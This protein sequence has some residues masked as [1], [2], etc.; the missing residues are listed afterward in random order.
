MNQRFY[1]A[2]MLLLFLNSAYAGSIDPTVEFQAE[3]LSRSNQKTLRWALKDS[4]KAT[5]LVFISSRCP[6]SAGHEIVLTKIAE[7][8]SSLGFRFIGVHANANESVSEARARFEDVKLGFPI[9]QDD[10][11]KIANLFGALK[12]PHVFIVSPSGEVLFSGGVDDSRTGL[13]PKHRYLED[14]LAALAEGKI[15]KE[16]E[17]RTLGCVIERP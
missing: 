3:V 10:G 9:V 13:N 5:V 6:C 16:K 2:F 15:P 1:C 8:Y 4:P 14:A 7:K 17:V 11:A 12:T